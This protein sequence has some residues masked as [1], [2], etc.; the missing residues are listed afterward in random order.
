MEKITVNKLQSGVSKIIREVETGEVYEVNRYS[1]KV[2]YLIPADKFDD[3]LT[4][5][6]CKKC[7]EELRDIKRKITHAGS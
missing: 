7:V 5:A 3:L 1:K 2:A 6:S 4:G